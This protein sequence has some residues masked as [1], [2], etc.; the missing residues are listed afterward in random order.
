MEKLMLKKKNK[1]RT[2]ISLFEIF[3]TGICKQLLS[4]L[5]SAPSNLSKSK[6]FCKKKKKKVSLGPKMTCLGA[7]RLIFGKTSFMLKKA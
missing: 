1:L 5:K 2:E 3:Y 7:F 6:V 4:Y